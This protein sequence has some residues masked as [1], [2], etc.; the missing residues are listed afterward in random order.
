MLQEKVRAAQIS[1]MSNSFLTVGKLI[2]GYIMGSTSVIAEG[3]HSGLDLVAAIIA[4]FSVKKAGQPADEEHQYGHGKYENVSG[5]V[6]A[7]LILLAAVMIVYESVKKLKSGGEIEQLGYGIIIMGISAV[8][9][10]F[11]SRNLM[12]VARKTD[13]IALEA[14]AWHLRTDVYTSVGV[15]AGLILIKITGLTILD[16][17]VAIAI[18]LL[19][20]KAAWDL[21]KQAVGDVLDVKLPQPEEDAIREILGTHNTE[22]VEYHKLRTRKSGAERYIDLHLVVPKNLSVDEGH[23]L[24]HQISAE[25][26]EKLANASV[27][28]HL[29]PCS[30]VWPE[31]QTEC[32]GNGQ[33]GNPGSGE[34]SN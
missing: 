30:S 17:V 11:V 32:A 4:L 1:V 33:K 34:N 7:V 10:Y 21:T 16:P 28:I 12:K 9:N 15:F 26:K 2:A 13:S 23:R 14:D 3:I 20:A 22:L 18:A 24:A 6:E 25:I 31:C 5:S 29:E 19:I 27:L 8:I